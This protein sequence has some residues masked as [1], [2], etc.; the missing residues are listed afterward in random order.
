MPPP[1]GPEVDPT[2]RPLPARISLRGQHA[3]L[4]PLHRRHA[5]ELWQAAQGADDS[6]TYL[7]AGPFASQ[8]AMA[9]HVM[10]LSVES[11]RMAWAVRPLTTGI[12]S[13]W[14]SLT[15]IQPWHASIEIGYI[16]F[17][18]R[19]QRT[20]AATEAIFLLLKL[21]AEDLGYRR[22]VWRCNALN[23]PSK[24]AAERLGFT[25][26]GTHRQ[27]MVVKGHLRDTDWYSIVAEE[28]PRVRDAL[29]AWLDPVNFDAG[30][31]A[32]HGLAELRE[33]LA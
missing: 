30:G 29:A 7:S 17:S 23:A 5:A 4:E 10:A 21:V 22:I 15:H 18:P 11:E 24:R 6:W 28:W 3:V 14:L 33:R 1:I 13:G 2:P 27:N 26:E 31:T 25:F 8:A 9:Q 16:W 20:R 12:V 19:L 32:L